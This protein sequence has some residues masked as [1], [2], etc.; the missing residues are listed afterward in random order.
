MKL[1]PRGA[2]T[3]APIPL[4]EYGEF[5]IGREAPND[6][7]LHDGAVSRNHAVIACEDGTCT[8][9]DLGSGNGTWVNGKRVTERRLKGGELLRF[10]SQLEFRLVGEVSEPAWKRLLGTLFRRG[11]LARDSGFEPRRTAIGGH[12]ILV[13]RSKQSSL[14]LPLSQVSEMHAR[15]ENRG[16][17]P[18][19]VDLK[20]RNG[21][22]VNGEPVKER[23]LEVGDEVGFADQPF[24]VVRTWVPTLRGSVVATGLGFLAA[25]IVFAS[26]WSPTPRLESLWTRSMYEEQVEQSLT[27]ALAA[28]DRR[29]PALEIAAAQ[30][31]IAVRSLQAADRLPPGRPADS[32]IEPAFREVSQRL[33]KVLAGRDLFTIFFSLSASAPDPAPVQTLVERRADIVQAELNRILAEFGIDPSKESVPA[34][35]L[36]EV[37]RYVDYWSGPMVGYSRRSV[38][39]AQPHL[40]MIRSELRAHRLPEVFCYLPFVESGYRTEAVSTAGAQGMW[41]FVKRTAESYGLRVDDSVDERTDAKLATD[42]ACRYLDGLLSAFGANAFMCAIAAYNKGEYGMVT[43]LKRTANDTPGAWRSRWK[44]WDLVERG[45]GCLKQETIEYVPKFLAAAIVMR[46]PDAFNLNEGGS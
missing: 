27:D 28:F 20:S 8:V 4:P 12:G 22:Y 2:Q 26:T 29:P 40:A 13:G 10:G 6:L 21:T 37:G 38:A 18:W 24:D 41:Q 34:A 32:D 31:D 16:G 19:V 44:F 11:L 9:R 46:R 43:C 25:G 39:R 5:R 3:S 7:P 14:R 1:L 15:V 30:F 17:V 35:L 45:D 36:A 33:G 23:C 42:A